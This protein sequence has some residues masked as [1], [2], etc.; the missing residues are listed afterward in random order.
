VSVLCATSAAFCTR[1]EMLNH[2]HFEMKRCKTSNVDAGHVCVS[3]Y[4]P[5]QLLFVQGKKC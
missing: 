5:H 3:L 1:N 2:V 4:V